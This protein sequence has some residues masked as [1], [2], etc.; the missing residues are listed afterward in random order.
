MINGQ[1][2]KKIRIIA[3]YLPQFHP[4]P[5]NDRWWGKGFTEWTNV[6][7]AKPLF[8]GH[9]QPKLPG[10]LG[11]YDLRIPEIRELQAK[12]AK[13]YGIEGFCY[14]HYWFG[15]GKKIL[16]KP[17]NEVLE[18]G[19][20][21]FPFCLAWANESWTGTWHNACGKI[22]Q[23]QLYPGGKDYIEHFN[24]L[25]KA[26]RDK[27][28]ITIEGKPLFI[29]YHP[30]DIPDLQY[31]IKI[32]KEKSI[33][34]GLEGIHIAGFSDSKIINPIRYGLDSIVY[35]NF[36]TLKKVSKEIYNKLYFK[37]K[38]NQLLYMIKKRPINI[39]D[40][41]DAIKV[42]N[43]YED[44]DFEYYPVAFPNWDNSPRCGK[45]SIIIN[46]STPELFEKHLEQ[47]INR[48]KKR[49]KEKQIIF[50]KSWN[51]WAEGNYL[52]PDANF[53]RKYLEVIQKVLSRLNK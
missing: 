48:I 30:S 40:Y 50:I 7:K 12:L 15:N 10:E 52:E 29:I 27:R 16:D 36:A 14:W 46:G 20:P 13:S 19:K 25:A 3:F 32:F 6:A 31:F 21:E 22:L 11:F 41:K 4:I 38:V 26:F 9:L 28:Y 42:W 47:I 1:Y 23:K 43:L 18:S 24:Y 51:E 8:K 45:N 34:I 39:Y 2:Q 49:S 17:F 33:N 53:K 35:S 44:F 37:R 5:E